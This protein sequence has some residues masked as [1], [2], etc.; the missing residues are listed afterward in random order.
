M[1]DTASSGVNA[2]L[3]NFLMLSN[4]RGLTGNSSGGVRLRMVRR[5]DCESYCLNMV[6]LSQRA[7]HGGVARRLFFKNICD[8]RNDD[9]AAADTAQFADG[10]REATARHNDRD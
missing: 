3:N 4:T 10:L 6:L 2:S 8:G 7:E 9:A 5:A 1:R